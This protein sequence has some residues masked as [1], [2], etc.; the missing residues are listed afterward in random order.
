MSRMNDENGF[1]GPNDLPKKKFLLCLFSRKYFQ[2]CG[3]NG[4]TCSSVGNVKWYIYF[5]NRLSF[6]NLSIH[7]PHD[8]TTPL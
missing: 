4:T 3:R 8:P 7:W 6:L 2:E 1:F 5:G